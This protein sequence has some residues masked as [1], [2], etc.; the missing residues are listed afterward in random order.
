MIEIALQNETG[1]RVRPLHGVNLAAPIV[2]AKIAKQISDDLRRLGIPLTRLHDAPLDNPGMRL[3][4][5]PCVFP[6]LKADPD[7]PDAYYFEQTDH[8]IQN[9]LDYGTRIMYRLGVS[10]E[11]SQHHYWTKPP[12][13]LQRWCRICQRIIEHY[14]QIEYWEIGNECD[15]E[16]PQLWDGTWREFITLYVK[17]SRY[18]K[19]RFPHLQVGGPSIARLNNHEGRYVREFL[20]ACRDEHAALDFFSWHQYSDKPQKII[21]QPMEVKALLDEYGFS[22]TELHLSEWHY[23]PGWGSD[24]TLERAKRVYDQMLGVDAAAYLGAVLCGWQDTPITMGEYYTGSCMQGYAL[25]EPNGMRTA[26]Y[27]VMEQFHR[28]TRQ[29]RGLSLTCSEAGNWAAGAATGD[30]LLILFSSF[31]TPQNEVTL[32]V[33]KHLLDPARCQITILDQLGGPH[34]LKQDVRWEPNQVTFEKSTGSAVILYE[35]NKAT[36]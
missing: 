35:L 29:E 18:I 10:I 16:I 27:E 32:N 4:D 26:G 12:E 22:R 17:A 21:D 13:D 7:D 20:S 14:P 5:I 30:Q 2:N 36:Q 28:L 23:H 24:C 1:T 33:G 15:E 3:V 9:A 11:H 25:F 8:Y 6:N 34:V 31:K 19:S